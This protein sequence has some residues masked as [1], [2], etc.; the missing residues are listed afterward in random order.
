MEKILQRLWS[1]V[2]ISLKMIFVTCP[3]PNGEDFSFLS[4]LAKMTLLGLSFC[5]FGERN[6]RERDEKEIREKE[7]IEIREHEKI[8]RREKE[9][10]LFKALTTP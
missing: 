6:K 8:D 1:H 10:V 4:K 7:E 5:P 9:R 2:P 3:S